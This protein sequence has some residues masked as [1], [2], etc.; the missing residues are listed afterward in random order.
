MNGI[1]PWTCWP[2]REL[3]DTLP[4]L[5]LDAES[6]LAG[7]RVVRPDQRT[8][9]AR[10]KLHPP[11]LAQLNHA[12]TLRLLAMLAQ[13]LESLARSTTRRGKLTSALRLFHASHELHRAGVCGAEPSAAMVGV[14]EK[15]L[16][17]LASARLSAL[18]MLADDE[19]G[20]S[21][22]AAGVLDELQLL[23]KSAWGRLPASFEPRLN[24]LLLLAIERQRT[25]LESDGQAHMQ[26]IRAAKATA[27]NLHSTPRLEGIQALWRQFDVPTDPLPL[28]DLL[29]TS[30]WENVDVAINTEDVEMLEHL[31]TRVEGT[32]KHNLRQRYPIVTGFRQPFSRLFDN[33]RQ[34]EVRFA[35]ATQLLAAHDPAALDAFRTLLHEKTED[36]SEVERIIV[37]EWYAY[38]L[39]KLGHTTDRHEIITLLEDT[40]QSGFFNIMFHWA[41]C[42]NLATAL[43]DVP[44]RAGE[45]LTVLL[46]TLMLDIHPPDLFAFAIHLALDSGHPATLRQLLPRATHREA[47]LLAILYDL[48]AARHSAQPDHRSLLVSLSRIRR[49]LDYRFPNPRR[50][51]TPPKLA[52]FTADFAKSGVT[53]AGIEWFHQHLFFG[54]QRYFYKNWQCLARLYDHSGDIDRAWEY[55]AQQWEVSRTRRNLP[56]SQKRKTLLDLLAWAEERGFEHDAATILRRDWQTAGL[57]ANDVAL[58]EVRLGLAPSRPA[59]ETPARSTAPPPP[60]D[61]NTPLVMLLDWENVKIS[62]LTCLR[63]LPPAERRAAQEQMLHPETLVRRM[64]RTALRFGRPKTAFAVANWKHPDFAEDYRLL[65]ELPHFELALPENRKINAADHVLVEKI[66]AVLREQPQVGVFVLGTGD[67]DFGQVVRTLQQQGKR[68]VLMSTR[69]SFSSAYKSYLTGPNPIEVV[70]LEDH[71]LTGPAT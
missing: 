38:A 26:F 56:P 36:G 48:R 58:H 52:T 27:I 37:Q 2:G 20:V 66:H 39:S 40:I 57:T 19:D 51:Y 21:P 71:V 18:S 17:A 32:L 10:L 63:D 60:S 45:A 34:T 50:S 8:S 29:P 61:P 5:V 6:Y 31:L 49:N 54:K 62:L 69:A 33:R 15:A 65:S 30:F 41:A 53:T 42:W 4:G 13:V 24:D 25:A 46:R 16:I 14:M 22:S 35:A 11:S 43:R 44:P 23:V 12:D 47:H 64:L 67:A 68:V 1:A 70:W 28:S 7:Q 3:I 55:Y 59:N 9:I